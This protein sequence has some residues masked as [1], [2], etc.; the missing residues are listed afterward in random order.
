MLFNLVKFLSELPIP[1]FDL[2]SSKIGKVINKIVK[3]KEDFED[4]VVQ[5]ASPLV[6]K[7]KGL[8]KD[9]KAAQ[10]EETRPFNNNNSASNMS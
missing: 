7:W 8:V 9:Y 1:A 6:N 5:I 10:E 3:T 2:M 4:R